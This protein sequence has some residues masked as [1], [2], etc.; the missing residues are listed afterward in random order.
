MHLRLSIM[1]NVITSIGV[2]TF[3]PFKGLFMVNTINRNH[4]TSDAPSDNDAVDNSIGSVLFRMAL[5]PRA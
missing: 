1:G 4:T 2:N 5:L 3:A